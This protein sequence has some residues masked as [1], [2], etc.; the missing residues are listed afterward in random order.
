MAR[1]QA[2]I[3]E[4]TVVELVRGQVGASGMRVT[5]S[6]VEGGEPGYGEFG[7][8]DD[9]GGAVVGQQ[10]GDGGGELV[11]GAA[12]HVGS[13]VGQVFGE[14]VDGLGFGGVPCSWR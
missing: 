13:V 11:G 1:A 14:Q 6:G 5:A 7:G 9:A 3:T 10:G 8:D 12:V 2:L 4:L